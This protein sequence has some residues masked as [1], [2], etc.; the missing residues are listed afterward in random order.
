MQRVFV[1][2]LVVVCGLMFA[3]PLL[4]VDSPKGMDLASL[5]TLDNAQ[6]NQM[7]G[8]GWIG[9]PY[10][11]AV[12]QGYLPN[13]PYQQGILKAWDNLGYKENGNGPKAVGHSRVFQGY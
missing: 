1:G 8:Q 2:L 9:Y 10:G 12:V 11:H 4:A 13:P 7:R 6:L 5:Q 3:S